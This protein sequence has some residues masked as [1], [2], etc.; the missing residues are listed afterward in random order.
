MNP[1]VDYLGTE[2]VKSLGDKKSIFP[3]LSFLKNNV[4][5]YNRLLH[6]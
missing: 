3:S 2:I 6:V 1:S 5:K 4:I